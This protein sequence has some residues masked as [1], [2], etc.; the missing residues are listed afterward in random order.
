MPPG[1][2]FE[3]I[4]R[5]FEPPTHLVVR[6]WLVR[7]ASA[8]EFWSFDR[9]PIFDLSKIRF[10]FSDAGKFEIRHRSNHSER[11]VWPRVKR[12]R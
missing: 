4:A 1:P 2:P 10:S 12:V 8:K 7:A 5:F 3:R 6:K 11:A 9:K